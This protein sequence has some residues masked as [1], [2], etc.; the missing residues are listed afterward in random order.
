M[1][2]VA[3][4][5]DSAIAIETLRR[6]LLTSQDYKLLWVAQTGRE[7]I[8]YCAQQCPDLLLMDMHM[9]NLNGVEATRQ[10][11]H[12][13]PCVILIVTASITKHSTM[14]FEAMSHGALDV[15]KTPRLGTDNPKAI[16][17]LLR[18]MAILAK[19]TIP[20]TETLRHIST[21]NP[22]QR[23]RRLAQHPKLIVIG[24][25][26]GGPGAL[27]TIFNQLPQ[28]FDA[29][30]IVIQ[31]INEQFTSGLV[32]W[33]NQSSKLPVTQIRNGDYPK[34]GQILLA[35]GNKH[36][37]MRPNHSLR[38]TCEP[39][40]YPYHPSVDVFFHSVADHWEQPGTAALLTGM[41]KDGALGLKHLWSANWHTI[42]ESKDSC[43]VFGMPKA[44]IEQGAAKHILSLNQVIAHFIGAI[45]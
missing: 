28:D 45:P 42:A 35:G 26:T 9:P 5:N 36:L 34:V 12:H 20:S 18:K 8:Q 24:A 11:M 41:G 4:V 2:T 29:A 43:V 25:S 3:I 30:I 23:S 31:H 6:A 14:V 22:R 38:Y 10:I 19:H 16:N 39:A 27:Q 15:V 13:S 1:L 7:A 21:S 40:N 32:H 37:V 33:L 44:A 17:R